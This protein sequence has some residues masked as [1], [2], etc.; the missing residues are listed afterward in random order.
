VTIRSA[1]R[2]APDI[3]F[4][5]CGAFLRK[6]NLRGADLRNADLTVALDEADLRGADLRGSSVD[7]SVEK[8]DFRKANLQGTDLRGS[9]YLETARLTAAKYDCNTK[10]PRG[11]EARKR[12]AIL[13]PF[14][15]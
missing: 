7:C 8:T 10:W 13:V 11:F 12:G 3:D 14:A 6:A 9:T 2:T 15:G 1:V 4:V 5:V